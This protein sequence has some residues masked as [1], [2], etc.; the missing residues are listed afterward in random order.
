MEQAMFLHSFVGFPIDFC[1]I[2]LEQNS[3]NIEA[4][5][6]LVSHKRIACR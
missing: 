6:L 3:F 5:R 2:A 4:V 1:L